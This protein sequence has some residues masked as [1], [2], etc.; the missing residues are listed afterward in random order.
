MDNK[1]SNFNEKRMSI[2]NELVKRYWNGIIKTSE[3]LNELA[4]D[5][6]V[7]YGFDDS[8]IPFIREHIRIAMGLDPKGDAEFSKELNQVK[9]VRKVRHPIVAKVEGPMSIVRMNDCV[10]GR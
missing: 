6:K 5:I 7:K 9:K 4:D 3:D 1:Y 8:E 10:H 2:F